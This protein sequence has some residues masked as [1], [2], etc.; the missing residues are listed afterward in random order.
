MVLRPNPSSV[1]LDD[2][3]RYGQPHPHTFRFV[4]KE[5]I[6]YFLQVGRGNTGSKIVNRYLRKGIV[7]L[8]VTCDDFALS[9]RCVG[10]GL[11]S[12]YDQIKNNLLNLN[13]I[14]VDLQHLLTWYVAYGTS[15]STGLDSEKVKNFTHD[16]IEVKILRLGRGILQDTSYA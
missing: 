15:T 13:P 16:L 4:G 2:G 8:H 7:Q 3:S 11:H 14:T 9:A 5:W 10:H 1:S 6:E 12:V